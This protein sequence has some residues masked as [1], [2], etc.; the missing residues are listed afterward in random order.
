MRPGS[1]TLEAPRGNRYAPAQSMR[2][3]M[4]MMILLN[5]YRDAMHYLQLRTSASVT[6]SWL[7]ALLD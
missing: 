1:R 7:L 6:C 4:M 3:M 2:L 5:A